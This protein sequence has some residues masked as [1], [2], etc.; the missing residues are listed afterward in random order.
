MGYNWDYLDKKAYN[1][2]VG[3][4]KYKR[5]FKFIV[6]NGRDNMFN[7]LDVCGGSGRFAIPLFEFTDKITVLDINKDAL[8]LLNERNAK[9]RLI[10]TDFKNL[11]IPESFNLILCIEAMGYFPDLEGFFCKIHTLLANDG[12]FIFSYNNPKS[13]RFFLRKI[14]HL[15]KGYYPYKEL[16]I[17]E[18]NLILNKYNFKVEKLEGMNWIPLSLHSNSF[19]VSVFEYF[20]KV[21]GL[22]HWHTQSPWLLFCVVKMN[23]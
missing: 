14:K 11:D 15:K 3:R 22:K 16:E 17:K 23:I 2:K 13:W 18:L 4:Y 19:L 1:N 20:E 6:E 21:L 5:Q 10:H 9:I 12:K 8:S 7:I